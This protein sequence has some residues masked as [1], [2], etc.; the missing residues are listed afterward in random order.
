LQQEVLPA[1]KTSEEEGKKSIAGVPGSDANEKKEKKPKISIFMTRVGKDKPA[2]AYYSA[3]NYYCSKSRYD[4]ALGFYEKALQLYRQSDDLVGQGDVYHSKGEIYFR[5]GK[6]VDAEEMFNEALLMYS[7]GNNLLGQGNAFRGMGDIFL[8]TGKYQKAHDMYRRALS[9]Y[10]NGKSLLGQGNA[11]IGEGE[12][13][14]MEENYDTAF[15]M[16]KKALEFYIKENSALGQGNAYNGIGDIYRITGKIEDALN[17]YHKALDFY[18]MTDDKSGPSAVFSDLGKIYL[19]LGEIDM[20]KEVCEKALKGFTKTDGL[21]EQGNFYLTKGDIFSMT[22]AKGKALEMYEK[23]LSFYERAKSPI[24]LGNV[25]KSKGDIYF[26][27]WHFPKAL[28]MY[29]AAVDYYVEINNYLGQGNVAVSMGDI[30]IMAGKSKK[31]LELYNQALIFYK[32]ANDVIGMEHAHIKIADIHLYEG[33]YENA[34]KGYNKAMQYQSKINS[35]IGQGVIYYMKGYTYLKMVDIKNAM[36]M[37]EKSRKIFADTKLT[38]LEALALFGLGKIYHMLKKDKKALEFYENGIEALEKIRVQ[39]IFSEMKMAFMRRSYEMYEEAIHFM[40][41]NKDNKRAFQV[42]ELMRARVFLER[43]A[44]G[45]ENID[46]GMEQKLKQKRNNL[47]SRLSVLKRK[48]AYE[49]G[50]NEKELKREMSQIE[51]Q[52]DNLDVEIQQENP[53]YAFLNWK[54]V[55][56]KELQKEVLKNDELLLE[57]VASKKGIYLFLVSRQDLKV[58]KLETSLD[59]IHDSFNKYLESIL[60]SSSQRP[61]SYSIKNEKIKHLES[62]YSFLLKPVEKEIEGKKLILAPDGRLAGIPFEA[63]V[64][65]RDKKTGKPVFLIEKYPV[66]YIQ[67]ASVLAF[68]RSRYKKEVINENLVAF[69]DPVYD[70]K[71]FQLGKPE[72]GNHRRLPDTREEVEAI[73]KV[74]REMGHSTVVYLRDNASEENA[75]SSAMNRFSYIH[76]ACHGISR[77]AGQG[78]FKVGFQSLV[79]TLKIPIP[80]VKEDGY[81]TLN[82]IMNCDY[83][84]QLVVLSACETNPGKIASGEGVIGLTRAVMYAGTPAAVATL[85]KVKDKAAKKLM[86]QFY[87]NLLENRMEKSEA[88]RKAKLELL[89]TG[90]YSSPQYWSAFVMYGE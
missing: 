36:K 64:S 87:K 55:E 88:L 34:L 77:F 47:V 60:K 75:K 8:K 41:T 43:L 44:E 28:E 1:V 20:A 10:V 68:L 40:L 35:L 14:K 42:A 46:K 52:L 51:I 82:E 53:E 76:F 54:P 49:T 22:G 17:M 23:A 3:A 19:G 65:S 26:W 9:C 4:I 89:K 56:L 58:K 57:Y 50:G 73:A 67:S 86:V 90:N 79:L 48:I 70:F 69:G 7:K 84:A 32:K 38:E 74:F 21:L 13:Y 12:V 37:F 59:K 16:Y 18:R 24:S 11:Y 6:D 83:N 5:S 72:D 71:S 27:L 2:D 85:W 29:R 61:R 81:F 39:T 45:I 15:E 33:D 30:L 66:K 80:G 78:I 31:A 63:L 62:L 25:Y